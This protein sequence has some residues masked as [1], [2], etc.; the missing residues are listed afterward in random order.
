M[1]EGRGLN[2]VPLHRL[3][4]EPGVGIIGCYLVDPGMNE[5]R[6]RDRPLR[7]LVGA[8]PRRRLGLEV[9]NLFHDRCAQRLPSVVADDIGPFTEQVQAFGVLCL[10]PVTRPALQFNREK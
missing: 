6:E 1:R 8:Q 4:V 5:T 3:G 9:T 10:F 7:S 2:F